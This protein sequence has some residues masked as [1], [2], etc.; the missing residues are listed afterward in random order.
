MLMSCAFRARY[1]VIIY[2]I[3]SLVI[4]ARIITSLCKRC[5]APFFARRISEK[6]G[7][8]CG[9]CACQNQR[10]ARI[11]RGVDH[12]PPSLAGLGVLLA[13]AQ[14]ERTLY[15]RPAVHNE[16]I[17]TSNLLL[18]AVKSFAQVNNS[19]K[20][21]CRVLLNSTSTLLSSCMS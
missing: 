20:L 12:R 6:P 13:A 16:H 9:S 8:V 15:R 5:V 1:D 18:L 3:T 4:G 2:T 14:S 19:H 10:S 7:P 21:F 11:D 17:F